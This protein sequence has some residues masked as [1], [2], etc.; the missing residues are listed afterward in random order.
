MATKSLLEFVYTSTSRS[1]FLNLYTF[2]ISHIDINIKISRKGK[3]TLKNV[4]C[5]FWRKYQNSVKRCCSLDLVV[6]FLVCLIP[7]NESLYE[8]NMLQKSY[9]NIIRFYW[10]IAFANNFLYNGQSNSKSLNNKKKFTTDFQNCRISMQNFK[11]IASVFTFRSSLV[12]NTMT[13]IQW[14]GIK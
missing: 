4:Y 5:P 2:W 14:C 6:F 12:T 9:Q 11:M 8:N 7:T 1:V 13:V 10:E 3:I